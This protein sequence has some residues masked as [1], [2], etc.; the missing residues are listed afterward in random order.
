MGD[1]LYSVSFLQS[2]PDKMTPLIKGLPDLFKD[3]A[4]QLQDR[5]QAACVGGQQAGPHLT[6]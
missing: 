4:T 6:W 2:N 5:L 3:S 1:V